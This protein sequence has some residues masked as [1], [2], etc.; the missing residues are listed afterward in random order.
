MCSLVEVYRRFRGVFCL[1]QGDDGGITLMR[2]PAST[3]ETSINF[4]KY[5]RRNKP[6]DSYLHN[7]ML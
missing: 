6:E 2:E 1:H 7:L 5:T 4:Y 3:S